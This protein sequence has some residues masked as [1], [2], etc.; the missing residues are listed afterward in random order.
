METGWKTRSP[1]LQV[2]THSFSNGVWGAPSGNYA[3]RTTHSLMAR[4]SL[5]LQRA[6]QPQRNG[7][8]GAPSGNYSLLPTP[9]SLSR[10]SPQS[11]PPDLSGDAHG[12]L[13][14][15]GLP[16]RLRPT[17]FATP[18]K[19][20]MGCPHRKLLTAH[21]ALL[22]SLPACRDVFAPP[23]LRNNKET[24]LSPSETTHYALRPTP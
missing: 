21:Y 2:T 18:K 7:V 15:C 1:F 13:A 10:G 16:R 4:H 19:R 24:G 5:A 14:E 20:G 11:R 17:R 12:A 3:L 22:T 9:Y 6:S 23:S 8:W